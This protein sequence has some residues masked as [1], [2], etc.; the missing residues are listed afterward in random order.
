MKSRKQFCPIL[1]RTQAV[2]GAAV[3]VAAVVACSPAPDSGNDENGAKSADKTAAHEDIADDP[4][5]R[6]PTAS[7]RWA[8][9]DRVV[10]VAS[11]PENR[12]EVWWTSNGKLQY[13]TGD[14][15]VIRLLDPSTGG[16]IKAFDVTDVEG[17]DDVDQVTPLADGD[18]FLVTAGEE[19][20]VLDSAEAS[21]TA[22]DSEVVTKAERAS[23]HPVRPGLFAHK[24]PILEAPSP[25]G[26]RLAGTMEA[27][28][29]VRSVESGEKRWLT[30]DGTEAV[31]W[32]VEGA[33]WAPE[34]RR[35]AVRRID[36]RDVPSVPIVDWLADRESVTRVD[37][38]R[39][40]EP[41]A[42]HEIHVLDTGSGEPVELE[43][44][45]VDA[46]Y[47]HVAGWSPD[48]S[49]VYVL[50][51]TRLMDRLDLVAADASTGE[52]R[53]L[54]TETSDTFIG[55][56]NFG[57]GYSDA[58]DDDAWVR[59]LPDG[60]GFVWTSSRDG[61]R[62]LYLYAPD[63][64]LQRP[65]TPGSWRVS[66]L[67]AIDPDHE[68]VW[69]T[70]A[71]DPDGH[72]GRLALY[73]APLSGGDPVKVADGP[74]FGSLTFAPGMESVVIER[75][76][77]ERPPSLELLRDD[78]TRV[79]TIWELD[80][81][82]L[83]RMAWKPPERVV[84]KAAD[85]ETDLYGHLYRPAGFNAESSYPVLELIYAGPQ[86]R[87]VR[88]V[89]RHH[90]SWMAAMWR[91]LG[92]AVVVFDARGTPG[93]SKAFQDVVHGA[94]GGHEVADHAAALRQVIAD[95]PWMDA[96]RVGVMGHSWGGYFALRAMLT[97]PELY[98]AGWASAP[99]VDL[100]NFRVAI[101]PYMG[102]LPETCPEAYA[103]GSNTALA[104]NL[105]GDLFLVHGTADDDVPFAESMKM[106]D[107]LIDAGKPF[108]FLPLPGAHHLP[109]GQ[110]YYWETTRRHM[111]QA[112]DAPAGPRPSSGGK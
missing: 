8:A 72:P 2:L 48:G 53:I 107:A 109:F 85:G 66:R 45:E 104:D 57:H 67:E 35:I 10:A 83:E 62:R 76:G 79:S 25:D 6:Q 9:S 101:E 31:A 55:G 52:T 19:S 51:M 99:T 29:Y 63:G 70:A 96:D 46:P 7:E 22:A 69:F 54:L 89:L 73:H 61:Y 24:P 16:D 26:T 11:S 65:L 111:V 108:D 88:R 4:A 100:E 47:L 36:R 39:P 40:G 97:E 41:I 56:L 68:R 32:D 1:V 30:D 110:P 43:L 93:R 94:V 78:G 105:E 71:A 103:A 102:C 20:F 21:V 74:E 27:N 77:L 95:R 58:L 84:V 98:R 60:K 34:G 86:S 15:T 64:K 50:R 90:Y 82:V 12:V 3:L 44:D 18:G 81:A 92:F 49:E 75:E 14:R 37:Y 80:A 17:A 106:V 59:F 5:A 33:R 87:A 42:H 23:P 13:L 38:S 91:Q 28:V 112:L